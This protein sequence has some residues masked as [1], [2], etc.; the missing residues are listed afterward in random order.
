MVDSEESCPVF[1]QEEMSVVLPRDDA[2]AEQRSVEEVLFKVQKSKVRSLCRIK[3]HG[4][5]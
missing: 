2:V 1:T 4:R 3:I 5:W